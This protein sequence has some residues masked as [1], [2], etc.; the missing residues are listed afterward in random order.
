MDID[1][2]TV[3]NE[4]EFYVEPSLNSV[5]GNRALAN[6][7]EIVMLTNWREYYYGDTGE[8]VLD[9]F[10]G[11]AFKTAS[12]VRNINDETSVTASMS[13]VVK[14]TVESIR[15]DEDDVI[16]DTER[17]ASANVSNVYVVG[18]TIYADITVIP[19]ERE[20]ESTNIS[21]PIAKAS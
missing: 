7:F 19:V 1:F 20:E 3:S 6:R 13:V 15:L 2:N 12:D 5:S 4:N 14:N 8:T 21:I 18:D 11:N 17:L 9:S 10:G 16:P